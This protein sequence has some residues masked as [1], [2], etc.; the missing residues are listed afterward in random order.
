MMD[1]HCH[2]DLYPNALSL[3][4]SVSKQNQFTL[5]VTTSPRAWV[6]TSMRFSKHSNVVVGLGLHPELA[7]DRKDE[8]VTMFQQMRSV[9]Y[10]GEVGID[11]SIRSKSTVDV[12][13]EIFKEIIDQ[14][15]MSGPH[16]VSIH[17]RSAATS[18]LNILETRSSDVHP[19]LHWF[20]GSLR[21]L[22]RAIT[23][24]CWFSVNP[25]MLD[26][27]H[28][29]D[30]ASHVPIDHIL[31]ET[32]GPFT[33]SNGQPYM[34]WDAMQIVK[35]LSIL[36]NQPQALVEQ[37]ILSNGHRILETVDTKI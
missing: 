7:A 13:T 12:Q 16:I 21:E 22:E 15:G 34:P 19:I 1:F 10:I 2:L 5:S 23:Q 28:G 33:N 14:C 30:I 24:N 35:T 3:L 26:S 32:D 29:R 9:R 17:S 27:T 31:P 36:N 4:P 37:I 8:L 20:S 25:K 11:G 6:A 18:V